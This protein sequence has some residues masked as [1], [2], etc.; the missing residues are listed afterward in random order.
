M[1]IYYT[2]DGSEP[3]TQ[4]QL[5]T[6]PFPAA[7]A[8][9]KAMAVIKDDRGAV[10]CLLPIRDVWQGSFLEPGLGWRILVVLTNIRQSNVR[11]YPTRPSSWY[12]WDF[13]WPGH[14]RSIAG[15]GRYR[16]L[17]PVLWFLWRQCFFPPTRDVGH[18]GY[19]LGA[20]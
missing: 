15:D 7:Q 19:R 9:I 16:P 18:G 13:R 5:Y 2:L 11:L 8:T 17:R 14:P 12:N 6:G 10:V 20:G 4:S 1:A 3:G